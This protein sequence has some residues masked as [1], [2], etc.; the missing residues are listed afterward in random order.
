LFMESAVDTFLKTVLQSGLLDPEQLQACYRAVP[1]EQ[2]N[3]PRAVAEQFIKTG[4]LSRFQATK[5]LAGT[6]KGLVFGPYQVLAPVG[7]G[8]M[9][10]VFL[11]RDSRD[12]RLVALKVLPPKKARRQERLLARFRREMDLCRRVSHPHIARTFE[13]GV[14]LGV[15]YIAMEFIP[16]RDLSKIVQEE[17]PLPVPRAAR[18]FAGVAAGLQHAHD[19]GL[20]HRDL[21]PSNIRVTP[22]DHAKILDLGLA[23]LEG[24]QAIDREVIGGPGYVVGSM[25]YIAPEQTLDAGG[26]DGRADIYSLGCSLYFALTGRPPFPGGT[27]RE[28]IMRQRSEEPA[29]VDAGNPQI[30]PHFAELVHRMMAKDPDLRLPSAAAVRREL[31]QWAS[32]DTHEPPDRP[33]DASFHVAVASLRNAET[34]ADLDAIAPEESAG[35]TADQ[36]LF[37]ILGGLVAAAVL[38]ATAILAMLFKTS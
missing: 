17:G 23:I 32:P 2:R 29:P 21:K 35:F 16:G 11:V 1:R 5:L 14:E 18:L 22:T 38:L 3:D 36:K 25:D 33:D 30:P 8:G 6:A 7:R 27:S 10:T 13:V 4:K 19:Q 15:Y 37:L 34:D 26:V 24:E 12:E 31:L 20:V 9:G 28:K